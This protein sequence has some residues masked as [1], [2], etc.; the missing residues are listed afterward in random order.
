MVR[1]DESSEM[2]DIIFGNPTDDIANHYDVDQG[3]TYFFASMIQQ[4]KY[5]YIS[6]VEKIQDGVKIKFGDF[7]VDTPHG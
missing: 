3:V 5:N 2:L 1:D 4:K 7:Y 6:E